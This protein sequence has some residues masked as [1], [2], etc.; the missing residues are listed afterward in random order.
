MENALL[1]KTNGICAA[2]QPRIGWS[3]VPLQETLPKLLER[4]TS[5]NPEC[6]LGKSKP[7]CYA[8]DHSFAGMHFGRLNQD[9]RD[10]E[11]IKRSD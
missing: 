2:S 1:I 7:T 9:S 8:L 4:A 11:Q 3:A 5:G 10:M 6:I